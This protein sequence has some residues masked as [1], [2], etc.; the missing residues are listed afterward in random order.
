MQNIFDNLYAN[1]VKRQKFSNL[2]DIVFSENNILLS[3]HNI[4][5]IRSWYI[6]GIDNYTIS[7]FEMLSLADI[8]QKIMD[9][10]YADG[11]YIP[12]PTQCKIVYKHNRMYSPFGIPCVVDCVIQQCIK[13][14][15]EPICEARFSNSSYAYRPL[16]NEEYAMKTL[17]RRIQLSKLYYVVELDIPKIY[18]QVNH[19]KLIRQLWS[20]GIQDKTLIYVIRR[21]LK[22][23]YLI[24]GKLQQ[25]SAGIIQSGVLAPLLLNVYLNEFDQWIESQWEENPI[26]YKYAVGHN[27]SGLPVKSAGYR[28]M[29]KTR[30]KQMYVLRFAHSIRISCN[31]K[32]DAEKIKL[33]I[34]RWMKK[35]IGLD[36]PENTVNVVNLKERYTKFLG[37]KVKVEL[38]SHKYV[39]RSHVDDTVMKNFSDALVHQ[40]RYIAS[41]RKGSTEYDEISL[42][43]LK[44]MRFRHYYSIA[45]MINDDCHFLGLRTY[46]VLHNRLSSQRGNRLLKNGRPLTKVEKFYFGKSA[47]V[48]YV[49]GTKEPIYPIAYI[50]YRNPVAPKKSQNVYTEQGRLELYRHINGS[51][52]ISLELL[53]NRLYDRSAAYVQNRLLL[54]DEQSGCCGISGTIFTSASDIHC[55][56]ITPKHLNGTDKKENLILVTN[57][58][59]R[60]IHATN[61]D[62][63]QEYANRVILTSQQIDKLNALRTQAGCKA[64]DIK[65][66]SRK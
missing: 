66:F 24:D 26:I 25:T 19:S 40:A 35:R 42:Y 36:I 33:G 55:H 21:I 45:T 5:K 48:R 22:G 39:V 18:Q 64:I 20:L 15:L 41:P 14:V 34:I 47:M 65:F 27:Q 9:S 59:H 30:L 44:V 54:Y 56:H 50:Q 4:E 11:G 61:P 57:N 12:K 58:I 37:F 29:Q 23:E 1:S 31:N 8:K 51:N 17:Y 38:R 49:A 63:I 52:T 7:D 62:T 32:V 6:S 43:N 10:I 16:R 46:T 13:Q 28:A 3:L 60:L 2:F 53:S